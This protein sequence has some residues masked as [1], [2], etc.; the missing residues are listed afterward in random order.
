[1]NTAETANL[2]VVR[3]YLAALGKGALGAALARFFT[4]EAV[5]IEL[6]NRL[7]PTGGQSDLPTLLERAERGHALLRSQSYQLRSEMAR[8]SHVAVEAVWT[9]ELALPLGSLPAG[10]TM[11]AHLAMFFEL[12]DG[13]ISSQRNYD[14]FEPW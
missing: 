6:P 9:A 4:P 3:S 14:C 1:M 8:G 12:T 10:S 2:M 13:R 5:Q 7:N 11:K